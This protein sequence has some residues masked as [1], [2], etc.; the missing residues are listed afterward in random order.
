MNQFLYTEAELLCLYDNMKP[1]GKRMLYSNNEG[2][3]V[4]IN[5]SSAI[6]VKIID[7]IKTIRSDSAL[8][9]NKISF[10]FDK[11]DLLDNFFPK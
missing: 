9:E 8:L 6:N 5:T 2:I 3:E 1:Y 7:T 4:K 10:L 11:I